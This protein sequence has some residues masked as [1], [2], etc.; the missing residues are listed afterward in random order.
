MAN[1]VIP[2]KSFS[3]TDYEVRIGGSS[4]N[5]TLAGAANPISTG[6]SNEDVF[7]PV[8]TQSG[9]VRMV[10][11][12]DSL[13]RTI[14]PTSAVS[15]PV[16]LVKINGSVET[17]MWVGYLAAENYG[18]DYLTRP[19]DHEFPL[20]CPLTVLES[21][22]IIPNDGDI[23]NFGW[24]LDYIF[25]KL[26]INWGNVYFQ[27]TDVMEWLKKKVMWSNFCDIDDDGNVTGKY[28]C[29]EVL[30]EVCKFWGWSCRLHGTDIWFCSPDDSIIAGE[31]FT[32]MDIQGLA[33]IGAGGTP[34]TAT[35]SNSRLVMTN[36]MFASA[37]NTEESHRGIKKATV[38]ADINKQDYF[39]DVDYSHIEDLYRS[40]TVTQETLA[41]DFYHFLKYYDPTANKS[42]DMGDFILETHAVNSDYYSS[43][44]IEE[45]F[46]GDISTK[47]NYNFET[48]LRMNG[49]Y[50]QLIDQE[51]RFPIVIKSKSS[52]NFDHGVFVISGETF[53]K[54]VNVSESEYKTRVGVGTLY[55][56][57]R[58]GDLYWTG[59]AWAAVPGDWERV[60][61]FGIPI[62]VENPPDP[63]SH[64]E[65]TGIGKIITNRNL[66]DPVDAYEGYGIP[67]TDAIGNRIGGKIT[68]EIYAVSQTWTNPGARFSLWFNSLK[69][70]FARNTNYEE[71][72]DKSSNTY[73]ASSNAVFTDTRDEQVIFAT[74]NNNKLGWGIIMNPDNTYCTNVHYSTGQ[75]SSAERPEQHLANRMAAFGRKVRFFIKTQLRYDQTGDITPGH[76]VQEIYGDDAYPVSISHEWRDDRVDVDM[77]EVTP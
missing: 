20:V 67:L 40:E 54:E 44:V 10:D 8:V 24:L 73:T 5:V 60:P 32:R 58:I 65:P 59:S 48:S 71:G 49:Q 66:T 68:L 2:F 39:V 53:K 21:F 15:R 52:Y 16:T 76:L 45:Y 3:G 64:E 37:S 75:G 11:M 63:F 56:R 17:V 61:P 7:A 19:Q 14:V 72:N 9:Y 41:T 74:D 42:Y 4:G 26:D 27:G 70:S 34:T 47:H 38:T 18:C 33:M 55:V 23:V 43:F 13:W 31:G 62:G 29:L 6:E 35:I 77:I 30:T 50:I 51:Y 28:N 46:S 1:W 25:S 57:L 12:N 22:D 36:A 69:M